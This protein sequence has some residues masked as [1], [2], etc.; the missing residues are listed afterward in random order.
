MSPAAALTLPTRPVCPPEFITGPNGNCYF[1]SY[2]LANYADAE[3]ACTGLGGVL[4]CVQDQ[5]EDEF[6]RDHLVTRKTGNVDYWIGYHDRGAESEFAWSGG[7]HS[8]YENWFVDEASGTYEPNNQGYGVNNDCVRMCPAE[9]NGNH[10][11]ADG[12][13]VTCTPGAW[14]DFDCAR[15]Y[16]YVCEVTPF[17]VNPAPPRFAIEPPCPEGYR[18]FNGNCYL[19][20][21]S[22]ARYAD[23]EHA[24][25][26]LNGTL[27]TIEDQRENDFVTEHLTAVIG[28]NDDYWIGFHDRGT[29]MNFEWSGGQTSS[30][31]NWQQCTVDQQCT[32]E[33]NGAGGNGESVGDCVR[34]CPAGGSTGKYGEC[35]PGKWAD[36]MCE[37]EFHYICEMADM[38]APLPATRCPRGYISYR[39]HCYYFA[40]Y[41]ASWEDASST[42]NSLGG[43]LA[44]IN[45]QEEDD[46][47]ANHLSTELTGNLDYWIGLNDVDTG[48]NIGPFSWAD[49]ETTYT[50]GNSYSHWLTGE[51]NNAANGL[52]RGDCVRI[53]PAG[54]SWGYA[55]AGGC[56]G[57][58]WG[59]FLCDYELPY[60]CEM[61]PFPP[62]HEPPAPAPCPQNYIA[63]GENCY[64]FSY[65]VAN[66]ADAEDACQTLGGV[67]SCIMDQQEDDFIRDHLV[68]RVAGN[69]DYWIGYHDR[70]A[71]AQFAWSGGCRSTYE[72]WFVDPQGR[73]VE[74]NNEDADGTE[75]DC[76]RMCPAET[77]GNHNADDGTAIVCTPGAWADF[78]C[79]QP[80]AYV[81]EVPRAGAEPAPHRPSLAPPCPVGF[82]L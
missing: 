66:Y 18:L 10:N 57:G 20:S 49:G 32:S 41:P 78:G 50:E 63:Q 27:A 40:H 67:L 19:F 51:P 3:N 73:I 82:L 69:L 58:Y 14:A 80:N 15:E 22:K 9:T 64:F 5:Q 45:S 36:Y 2:D 29:E 21:S 72:H 71:E 46:F 75:G 76:V 43:A 30:Y 62:P 35:I 70:G 55:T 68:S 56:P 34:M 53:C 12:T 59:D 81:C 47:I 52:G 44:T 54:E 23:A 37:A 28:G 77:N 11:L 24:C 1:F 79:E 31:T 17:S 25:E 16:G 33:P 61:R 42:C 13:A 39:A 48:E 38:V 8:T 6:I 74:P 60:V 7:C 26:R 65:D 4:A